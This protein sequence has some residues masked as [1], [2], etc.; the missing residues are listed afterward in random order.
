MERPSPPGGLPAHSRLY[1]HVRGGP[2]GSAIVPVLQESG[3]RLGNAARTPE[4]G[5]FGLADHRRGTAG[6]ADRCQ[7]AGKKDHAV[8]LVR[9]IRPGVPH[10]HLR[11]VHGVDSVADPG[12]PRQTNHDCDDEPVDQVHDAG[13]P[14]EVHGAVGIEQHGGVDPGTVDRCPALQVC[15]PQGTG[16]VCF[17][18]V[19]SEHGLGRN[20]FERKPGGKCLH[21]RRNRKH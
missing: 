4:L 6:R 17:L 7:G 18:P 2:G 3:G 9:G 5:L 20:L 21:A 11:R 12:G 16:I 10:D 15:R 13:E 19:C 8:S 14:N 1:R